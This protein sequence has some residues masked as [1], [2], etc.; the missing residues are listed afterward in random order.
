MTKL[1]G[2]LMVVGLWSGCGKEI[3]VVVE[4]N[5]EYEI[6]RDETN[7]NPIRHGY[8]KKY[9]PDKSYETTGNFV[10]GKQEGKWVYNYE[11]GKV[12]SDEN[13][14]DGKKEGKWVGYHENGKVKWEG[15][16]VGGKQEGKSVGY[17]ESGK[18]NEEGNY[19]D[20]KQEGKWFW[21]D[22]SGK[23]E[24]EVNY[25]GGKE[26][27]K[28]VEYDEEGNITDEDIYKDGVCVEMCEGD[29]RE[30]KHARDIE[31]HN[32]YLQGEGLFDQK[33]YDEAVEIYKQVQVEYPESDYVIKSMANIGAAFMAQEE[34]RQAGAVFQEVVDKYSANINEKYVVD[35]CKQ[36]LEAMQE[37]GVL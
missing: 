7:N 2:I 3:E 34:Y 16:F 23:V 13:Y 1:I 32:L 10:D 11:S 6:Y 25:V 9:Y 19:V 37:A 20:G 31:A 27:G 24:W 4:G 12:S 15:N 29:D 17:F 26:E 28:V 33:K 18:V 5:E 8:Y 35:F 30:L 36:Q 21:Y 22:E 14:I